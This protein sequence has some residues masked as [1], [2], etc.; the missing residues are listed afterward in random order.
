MP[1]RF[2]RPRP[3]SRFVPDADEVVLVPMTVGETTPKLSE[4][5]GTKRV[6]LVAAPPLAGAA[7]D[8]PASA[9]TGAAGVIE[10]M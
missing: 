2:F 6:M 9:S 3:S 1:P 10:S 4:V 5:R 7:G 8:G